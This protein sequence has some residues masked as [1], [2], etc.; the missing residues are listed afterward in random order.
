VKIRGI[1]LGKRT[2]FLFLISFTVGNFIAFNSKSVLNWVLGATAISIIFTTIG[3]V[4]ENYSSNIKVVSLSIVV[5]MTGFFGLILSSGGLMCTDDSVEVYKIAENSI[6]GEVK[7]KKFSGS[8]SCGKFSFPWYFN[9]VNY[10]QKIEYC[11]EN[12]NKE[13]CLHNETILKDSIRSSSDEQVRQYY[14]KS[15]WRKDGD[16]IMDQEEFIYRI[17]SIPKDNGLEEMWLDQ[18]RDLLKRKDS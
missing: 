17:K 14:N 9:S 7:A 8:S 2:F 5:L 3:L 11:S 4:W 1:E 10:T 16:L 13:Y 12:L 18:T 6:N 15:H